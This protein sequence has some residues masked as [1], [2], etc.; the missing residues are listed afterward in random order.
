MAKLVLTDLTNITTSVSDINAN[1]AA[2]E[3]ALENT[4]S[5]DGTSPNAMGADLDM[6]SKRL[7]NLGAPGAASDAARLS[8]IT[9]GSGADMALLSAASG[10][11]LVGFTQSG[12]GAVAWTVQGQLRKF[13]FLTDFS[14]QANYDTFKDALTGTMAV[15]SLD[16]VSNLTVSGDGPHAI[17]TTDGV[18]Q[19]N[20][21][22][23]FGSPNSTW[24]VA[25]A[26][27]HAV[28]INQTLFHDD[29]FSATGLRIA[30]AFRNAVSGNHPLWAGLYL[31]PLFSGTGGATITRASAI[32]IPT[33]SVN[34][35][36]ANASGLYIAG[37]PTGAST[38]RSLWVEGGSV[39]FTSPGPHAIGGVVNNDVSV[40]HTGTFGAGTT[41]AHGFYQDLTLNVQANGFGAGMRLN[42]TLNKAGSGTHSDFTGLLLN[43]PTIGAGAAALT[44]ASTLKITAAPTGA[45]NNYALWVDAGNVRIDSLAG[46]GSRTV[47]ADANGVL[48]AP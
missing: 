36:V 15:P 7:I 6:N 4:L 40:I 37:A 33:F 18:V 3:A 30:V 27:T 29:G 12:A 34:A 24:T 19:S 10:S 44:N 9:P 22:V 35:L 20:V 42:T 28:G 26:D 1:S 46:A 48:S 41:N 16:V 13:G 2:I 17:G 21:A 45:T 11:S 38:N 23:A 47:V 14:S 25:G 39:E 32:H 43:P 5:R 31:S 8:D